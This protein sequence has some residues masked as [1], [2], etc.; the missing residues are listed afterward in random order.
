MVFNM[1]LFFMDYHQI[2]KKFLPKVSVDCF[3]VPLRSTPRNDGQVSVIARS[4]RRSNPCY[5]HN[6]GQWIASLGS[7][8]QKICFANF[9]TFYFLLSIYLSGGTS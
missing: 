5:L 4:L 3:V 7:Q 1:G 8:R 2:D 9:P 6:D